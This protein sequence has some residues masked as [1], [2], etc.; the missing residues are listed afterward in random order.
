MRLIYNFEHV[1]REQHIYIEV[2]MITRCHE[3]IIMRYEI[4]P[5]SEQCGLHHIKFEAQEV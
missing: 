1:S 5:L 3:V 2:V 4:E